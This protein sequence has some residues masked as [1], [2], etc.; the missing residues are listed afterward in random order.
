MKNVNLSDSSS[1][2]EFWCIQDVSRDLT[3]LDECIQTTAQ[4]DNEI[5][6][7]DEE[8]ELYI[9][10]CVAVWTNGAF[11]IAKQRNMPT[12]CF[13]AQT[14]YRF[15]FFCP[16]NFFISPNPD[17]R[18]ETL[19]KILLN[20]DRKSKEDSIKYGICL[21]DTETLRVYSPCG[22][23]YRTSFPF[24]V[25]NVM[26]TKY[27]LLL[28]KNASTSSVDDIHLM[29]MPRVYTLTHPLNDICPILLK[30]LNGHISFITE[31]RIAVAFTVMEYNLVM[32]HDGKIGKHVLCKL[33]KATQ[34]EKQKVGGNLK[35]ITK[36]FLPH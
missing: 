24:P 12:T 23:D 1:P 15:A 33:R 17:K 34:D 32:I 19:R 4:V 21:I 28:E 5:F 20:S 22:E 31:Q 10:G 8:H 14:N 25:S 13:T 11:E 3:K 16:S 9:K 26:Q 2:S 18:D 35:L 36:L 30:S 29:A 27:G 6:K 7:R